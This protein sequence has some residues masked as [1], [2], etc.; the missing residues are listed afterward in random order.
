MRIPDTSFRLR[1]LPDR[2]RQPVRLLLVHRQPRRPA[3]RESVID[4]RID[5]LLKDCVIQHVG[6][7][8]RQCR[9]QSRLLPRRFVRGVRL[10]H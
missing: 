1:P 6:I 4:F 2:L 8:V 9:R 3:P 5:Q 10:C 7:D